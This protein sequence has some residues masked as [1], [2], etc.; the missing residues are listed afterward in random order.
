MVRALPKPAC[1]SLPTIFSSILPPFPWLQFQTSTVGSSF[2][3]S[4]WIES[5]PPLICLPPHFLQSQ[6]LHPLTT[7][8]G[9]STLSVFNNSRFVFCFLLPPFIRASLLC[10]LLPPSTT[11]I[12]PTISPSLTRMASFLKGFYPQ[13][14]LKHSHILSL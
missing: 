1:C 5:I 9:F 8:L 14:S 6:S 10:A 2:P 11:S 13:E 7:S 4:W 12:P 3:P